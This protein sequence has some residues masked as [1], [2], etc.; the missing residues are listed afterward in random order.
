VRTTLLFGTLLVAC[1]AIA[2]LLL[3]EGG[4]PGGGAQPAPATEAVAAPEGLRGGSQPEGDVFR[5]WRTWATLREDVRDALAEGETLEEVFRDVSGLLR[6]SAAAFLRRAA[7]DEKSPRVRALLVLAAGRH[8]PDDP[9]LLR[10]LDDRFAVVRAAAALAAGWQDDA[11]VVTFL[12][13]VRVPVGRPLP[14]ETEARVRAALER[15]ADAGAR[16]AMVAVLPRD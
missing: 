8:V 14:P 2:A 6:G 15:E 7:T 11:Q 16:A 12:E 13:H 9:V 10:F 1:A 4:A 5:E 3:F